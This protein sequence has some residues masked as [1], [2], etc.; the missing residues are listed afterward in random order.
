MRNTPFLSQEVI[1]DWWSDAD[2][3]ILKIDVHMQV[4][5][6]QRWRQI[7]RM[8]ILLILLLL[9]T[10]QSCLPVMRRRLL[11]RK[12]ALLNKISYAYISNGRDKSSYRRFVLFGS[13]ETFHRD[14]R[15]KYVYALWMKNGDNSMIIPFKKRLGRN[16]RYQLTGFNFL[17]EICSC[18][19][20]IIQF[21]KWKKQEQHLPISKR[22]GYGEITIKW[23]H[24][25]VEHRR[26]RGE[27]IN[28]QP[29]ITNAFTWNEI[30]I[31]VIL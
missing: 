20:G 26:I 22:P 21:I 3:A 17:P 16:Y 2:V 8:C 5:W 23:D 18:T 24:K 14:K 12:W 27:I 1:S 6:N 30:K 10:P 28:S 19:K 29:S 9:H 13:N 11:L 4:I 15:I 31:R 7:G 25:Q